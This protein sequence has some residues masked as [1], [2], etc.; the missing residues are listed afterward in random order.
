MKTYWLLGKGTM[1]NENLIGERF[2]S[3]DNISMCPMASIVMEEISR[4]SSSPEVNFPSRTLDMR[5]MYSP[6]SFDDVQRSKT[7]LVSHEDLR[8]HRN[9][10]GGLNSTEHSPKM[11]TIQEQHSNNNGLLTLQQHNAEK[12]NVDI[13][14]VN[15]VSENNLNGS[16]K[17]GYVTEKAVPILPSPDAKK[18][19]NIKIES[20]MKKNSTHEK[21]NC[22]NSQ[23]STC[24]V[25]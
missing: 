11:V 24:I 15:N 12:L 8:L 5:A 25:T 10:M 13:S 6:V 22:K 2:T 21:L 9:N 19:S 20:Q 3:D 14:K 16:I 7:P 17:N 4:R 23:S 1:V 18:E